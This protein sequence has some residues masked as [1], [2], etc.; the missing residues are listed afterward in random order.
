MVLTWKS[1]LTMGIV[2]GMVA[3]TEVREVLAALAIKL[4]ATTQPL[5]GRDVG[6]ALFG[7]REMD[8]TAVEVRVVLGTL[9]HKLRVSNVNLGIG[10]LGRAIVGVLGAQPW[11]KEE[12]L[13]VLASKTPGMTFN[14]SKHI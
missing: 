12:F 2:Q 13:S 8:C 6:M 14:P 5:S 7:L 1:Y 4:L 3:S 11:I 9:L 10:D